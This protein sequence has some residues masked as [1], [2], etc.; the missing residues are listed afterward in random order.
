MYFR[1]H[2]RQ[3]R[4]AWMPGL[5]HR[6]V[7]SSVRVGFGA[8][9]G[10]GCEAAALCHH[11][12]GQIHCSP[13]LCMLYIVW[14]LHMMYGHVGWVVEVLF[15]SQGV[16][17][18]VNKSR[19]CGRLVQHMPKFYDMLASIMLLL[20]HHGSLA[21]CVKKFSPWKPVVMCRICIYFLY[22]LR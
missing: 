11:F 16:S 18:Y 17:I 22:M 8:D 3:I 10:Y 2:A 20:W 4:W 13:C 14:D 5:K 21:D 1:V 12:F 19:M 7:D 6:F 15:M 9:I